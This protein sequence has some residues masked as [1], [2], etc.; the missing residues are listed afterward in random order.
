MAPTNAQP[1][2]AARPPVPRGALDAF[3]P[4]LALPSWARRAYEA[5]PSGGERPTRATAARYAALT[6]VG[7]AALTLAHWLAG[8]GAGAL[9]A[10]VA[11][12]RTMDWV[13]GHPVAGGALFAAVEAAAV[14]ALLPASL[15]CLLAGAFFGPV[16]GALISWAGLAAGQAAAFALGRTL[17]RARVAAWLAS[18][19]PRFAT[20]DAA[21]T[22]G[23]WRLVALLRLSPAVPWNALNYVLPA[24]G[25]KPLPAIL[26]SAAAV[27]PWC[28]A[29]AY[30]GSLAASLADIV[31]GRAGPAG[32]AA[33]GL[34]ALG[35][36][37]AAAAASYVVL[38][39][40][41]SVGA[42]L[43]A[44]GGGAE[45]AVVDTLG[46][47]DDAPWGGGGPPPPPPVDV[48][49][50]AVGARVERERT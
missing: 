46:D 11:D 3:L 30:L 24:T 19:P 14:V 4:R 9:A 28:A 38:L 35:A 50:A 41:R 29:F 36:A 12:P 34:A 23:G 13:A 48:E 27:A 43:K 6:A 42:A 1:P 18:A 25:V 37:L 49:L 10:A 26:A 47:G 45:R 20:L 15:F 5:L 40:R 8:G 44:G 33:V 7:V 39:A 21:V 17:L 2:P 22:R 32:P 31:E 16:V